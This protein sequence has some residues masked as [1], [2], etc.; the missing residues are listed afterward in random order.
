[1]LREL[2]D[3]PDT[4]LDEATR[5]HVNGQFDLAERRFAAILHTAA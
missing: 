3:R 2:L 1:V 5:R 4:P